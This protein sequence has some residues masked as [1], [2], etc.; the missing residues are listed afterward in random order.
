MLSNFSIFV[1][2]LQLANDMQSTLPKTF[3]NCC[4]TLREKKEVFENIF[5]LQ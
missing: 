3:Y 4:V 1:L 2:L 5:V